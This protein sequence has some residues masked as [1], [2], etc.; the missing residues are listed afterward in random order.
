MVSARQA[1]EYSIIPSGVFFAH[2]HMYKWYDTRV[3]GTVRHE[4]FFGTA[5]RKKSLQ[6]R[7][8]VFIRPEDH[9]MSDLGVHGRYGDEFN[10][11]LKQVAQK[12]AMAVYGWSEEDFIK[13]FGRSYI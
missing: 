8:Y 13:V 12:A 11:H 1:D 6:F 4:V 3:S 5:N 2:G 7:L 10:R 9:N